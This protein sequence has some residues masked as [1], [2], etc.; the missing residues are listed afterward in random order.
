MFAKYIPLLKGVLVVASFVA[1]VSCVGEPELETPQKPTLRTKI[2]NTCDGAVS[3]RMVVYVDDSTANEW[4][5]SAEPTRATAACLGAAAEELC[6]EHIRPVFNLAV[7]GDVK[8]ERGMHRW[9]VVEFTQECD[10]EVAARHLASISSVERVEY[11]KR[12]VRPEVNVVPCNE[13]PATRSEVSYPFDDPMLPLQWALNNRGD[14]TIFSTA[15]AGEDINA[16]AA[17]K[18]TAGNNQVVV[19]VM[20]EGVKYTHPDLAA[21]MW[22]NN[23]ELNG[24]EGVDDDKNGIVDDI[25]GVN[26]VDFATSGKLSGN[27][28]WAEGVWK[29]DSKGRSYYDGDTGHGTHVAGTVAAVNN[30][31]VG[32]AG[33]AG[34]SGNGDGVRIMSIQIFDGDGNSSYHTNARGIE[35]AADHGA[36]ILQCSWGYPLSENAKM[37]DSDYEMMGGGA[38]LAALRYFVSQSGCSTMDGNVVIF[39]AGNEGKSTADYPG[40]YNEFI[41]VTAYAPDGL[42]TSYTNYKEGCNVSAP[43]G[44]WWVTDIYGN[45]TSNGCVLS[46][47][48]SETIDPLTGSPYGED[49]GYMQGTS[50]ACPHVSGIAA[51]VVSYAL[52]NGIKMTNTQLY[53][54]LTSAVRD[55]DSKLT[56]TRSYGI[57]RSFTLDPY[58]GN[59]GTGKL[60]ALMAIQSVRGTICVPAI[61]GEEVV[62]DPSMLIGDGSVKINVTGST[63]TFKMSQETKERLGIDKVDTFGGKVYFTPKNTGIGMV[64]IKYIAGGKTVGGG[65]TTGGKLMEKDVVVVVRDVNDNGGWM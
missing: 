64:T 35:Y 3:G 62:L 53:D 23:A 44:D 14:K 19:A 46:T 33:V 56:G 16:F 17:W 54:I 45:Y 18:Y 6:V 43:G 41:A 30:N 12:V 61:V 38:E 8:R 60:D 27:I 57:S 51:L 36:C 50:M 21:N 59:M 13:V 32:V 31:G 34:G 28:S 52:E 39:A 58:K 1:A 7:N 42:P 29:T 63:D 15:V 5:A 47:I 2:I 25:Y 40:A 55:I 11:V 20:D 26:C 24:A 22:T 37:S 48:P 65:N 9:F 4:L 10:V 49:Y